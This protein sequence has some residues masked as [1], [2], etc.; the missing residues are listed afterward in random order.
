MG[1][2]SIKFRERLY[3]YGEPGQTA[4][5]STPVIYGRFPKHAVKKSP[6]QK[7]NKLLVMISILCVCLS[8]VSYYFV[9]DSERTMNNLGR[10]I[11]ALSSE[12]MEL[13]NKID[14]MHS[15]NKVD[16]YIQNKTLL[17][18]AKKVIEIPAVSTV[19]APKLQP[20]PVNYRWSVG[21]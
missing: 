7:L 4:H 14:N 13:Q 17:A 20:V 11:V 6:A 3:V 12:N 1:T 10:E 2:S 21:Y 18:S 19:K 5:V 8:L 9:S 15:F 16:A